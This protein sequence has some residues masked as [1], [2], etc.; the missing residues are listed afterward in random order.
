MQRFFRILEIPDD[1]SLP[2]LGFWT[3]I[4]NHGQ[5][6]YYLRV[7]PIACRMPLAYG[8]GTAV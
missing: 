6:R 8:L 7:N 2:E 4:V 5:M 1:G 3:D